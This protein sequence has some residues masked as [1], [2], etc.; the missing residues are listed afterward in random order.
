MHASERTTPTGSPNLDDE[1][2]RE[3]NRDV[4]VADR[5]YENPDDG[6]RNIAGVAE[7]ADARD[8]K[9]GL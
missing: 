6:L 9:S 2:D 8:S 5:E 4:H 1:P 3:E 7:L